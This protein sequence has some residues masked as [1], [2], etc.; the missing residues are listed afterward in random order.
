MKEIKIS[1]IYVWILSQTFLSILFY[2]NDDFIDGW[3]ALSIFVASFPLTIFIQWLR[4]EY[5]Q[6]KTDLGDFNNQ[7]V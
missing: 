5:K 3:E 4:G 2:L 7:D 6:E 1:T